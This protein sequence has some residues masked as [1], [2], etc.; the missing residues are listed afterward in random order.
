MK[1]YLVKTPKIVPRMFPK[2]VWAFP[3]SN[4][5]VYLSFDDG[6]IPE[7]TPWVLEE[8][9]KYNAKATFF[10][11]G[12][13]IQKHTDVFKAIVA[14]GHA[15][16][17]HTYNHL[18]GWK[19]DASVYI[20]NVRMVNAL[21]EQITNPVSGIPTETSLFRPPYGR[22]TNEQ[23][24]LLQEKGYKIIMWDV[25]SADYDPK[26]SKEKCLQLV[27]KNMHAGSIVCFHDS[28]KAQKKLHFVLPKLLKYISEKGWECK[29]IP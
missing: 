2:R 23:S 22:L 14:E 6:P 24:K 17:N 8:L 28:L 29:S 15:I 12:D 11:I 1:P 19:T 25:L 26:L 18:N 7:V 4:D 3:N 16:G 21:L 9:K 13:N 20:E 5:A 27:K 10:C